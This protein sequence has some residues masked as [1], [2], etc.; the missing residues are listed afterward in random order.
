MTFRA[1]LLFGAPGSGKGTQGRILGAIPNFFHCP[2]GDVF[3][4]LRLD[5]ELGRVFAEY[6]SRG[7]L[8]PDGPTVR[9][10]RQF[11]EASRQAGRFNPETDTV[12]LD[13][14]PRN[15]GQAEMLRDT[16]EVR[17]IFYLTCPARDQLV[18][19]LQR[20]AL[21]ENRLDDANLEVIRSRLA[22]YERESRPV[23]DFYGPA[24]LR[25]IDATQSPIVVLHEI[26]TTLVSF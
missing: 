4:N 14:I 15:L 24:R 6:S 18:E 20:R 7:E 1:I 3:R 5:S 21:R 23:L 19:R 11:I 16:L 22:T 2:C 8:V 12:V 10:W 13:G 9:L 17:A 26:L 25:T